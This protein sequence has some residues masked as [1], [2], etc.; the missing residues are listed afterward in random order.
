M[1]RISDQHFVMLAGD[2]PE[3]AWDEVTIAYVR[4][5]WLIEEMENVLRLL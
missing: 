4:E 5:D 3:S 1:E 2:A